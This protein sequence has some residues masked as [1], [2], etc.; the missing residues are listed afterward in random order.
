MGNRS[1]PAVCLGAP[2]SFTGASGHPNSNPW[3]NK[4]SE[5]F[6]GTSISEHIPVVAVGVS[7]QT[8]ILIAVVCSVILSTVGQ[9]AV[10]SASNRAVR[11]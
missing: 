6:S 4:H 8:D 5:Y 1:V 10:I 9:R 11:V 3:W 2:I 7:T